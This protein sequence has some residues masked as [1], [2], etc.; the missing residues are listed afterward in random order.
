MRMLWK[1]GC[2]SWKWVAPVLLQVLL[3][4]GVPSYV[5]QAHWPY[6]DFGSHIESLNQDSVLTLTWTKRLQEDEALR[7]FAPGDTIYCLSRSSQ[8]LRFTKQA[9][10][11]GTMFSAIGD[12]R[13]A[14]FG[15]TAFF[16][17]SRFL[18]GLISWGASFGDQSVAMFDACHFYRGVMFQGTQFRSTVN[19]NASFF[20]QS[21]MI[22][23]ASAE[24]HDLA[25]FR[26]TII[27]GDLE[28]SDVYFGENAPVY[29]DSAVVHGT[30]R[31]D[32]ASLLGGAGFRRSS[33]KKGA[34]FRS[35]VIGDPNCDVSAVKLD[36]AN[37]SVGGN[38]V[39]DGASLFGKADFRGTTFEPYSVSDDPATSAS[40]ALPFVYVWSSTPSVSFRGTRI[41]DTVFIGDSKRWNPQAY[42]FR[43]ALFVE[44]GTSASNSPGS[45]LTSTESTAQSPSPSIVYQGH[46]AIV[47][48]GP[49]HLK[50]LL[51]DMDLLSYSPDL[52]NE[53]MENINTFLMRQ[54]FSAPAQHA[55]RLELDYILAAA[56]SPPSWWAGVWKD[57]TYLLCGY[58]YRP[59][60]LAYWALCIMA[61]FSLIY[62]FPRNFRK[63]VCRIVYI[64]SMAMDESS[65][66]LEE[67]L[68]RGESSFT[69]LFHCVHYS[70]L[71]LFSYKLFS[72]SLI[73]LSANQKKVVLCEWLVGKSLILCFIFL[74][75][76]GTVVPSFLRTLFSV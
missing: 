12:F 25:T 46:A 60:W 72:T 33:L 27:L 26:K 9:S 19:F 56:K 68:D 49:V 32:S 30:I 57:L 20:E 43:Y 40:D 50:L 59:T 45:I 61:I 10:F 15:D 4:V 29:F 38:I 21:A 47:L 5:L 8:R 41:Y 48:H 52:S 3:L 28:F 54:S 14:H 58:G 37:A 17:N 65:E 55:E 23:F 73:L 76:L 7:Q 31:F 16:S 13:F 36:M 71:V 63:V 18:G 67:Y 44:G 39:F 75:N 34:C 2:I 62:Y 64:R 6:T 22:S 69:H 11:S 70:I 42:D 66:K 24:F 1:D 35:A 51:K 74:S 53:E